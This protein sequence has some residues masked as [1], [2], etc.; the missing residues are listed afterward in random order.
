[1]EGKAA[2]GE[3]DFSSRLLWQPLAAVYEALE[4]YNTLYKTHVL[5]AL[6]QGGSMEVDPTAPT[7]LYLRDTWKLVPLAAECAGCGS[8]T[9]PCSKEGKSKNVKSSLKI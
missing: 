5:K 9:H 6:G 7:P 3:K 2:G 4:M 8:Q 1:M